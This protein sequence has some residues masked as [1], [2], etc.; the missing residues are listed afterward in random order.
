MKAVWL[1]P[2]GNLEALRMEDM[3]D[4][5]DPGPG[6]IRVRLHA[7]SL[8]FHDLLVVSGRMAPATPLGEGRIPMS[9]GAAMVEAVGDGVT[10]FAVGDAVISLIFPQWQDGGAAVASFSGTPGDGLDG[11][12]R[13][14]VIAPATWFT[15]APRGYSHA[16]AATV[17]VAGLTA[18]RALV[19]DG[20]LKP[21]DV[22]LTLGTGGVSIFALQLA[23]AM[24][25]RV[26]V[27]SSSDAKLERARALGADHTINYRTTEQWAGAVLE[28]TEGRGADHV[29]EIGGPGTLSQ[30]M[31]AC[32]IGGRIAMIGIL[33]GAKGEVRTGLLIGRQQRLQGLLAGSR[34]HQQDLVRALDGLSLRPVID[35]TFPLEQTADAFRY[36][37]SGQHF[38]KI[39]LEI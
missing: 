36:E 13:E 17:V 31:E 15:R 14:A 12:A 22:V 34:K 32:R 8:N 23:K 16:E 25:A 33:T 35:R 39:C 37:M 38:G 29:M 2:P 11:Y 27:T 7:S 5:G 9:D 20:G 26:I 24:G 19:V 1:R 4:P 10:E 18:W 6:A 21:G 28:L 30:S 3:A